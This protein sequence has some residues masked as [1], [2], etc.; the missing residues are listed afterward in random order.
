MIW[1][2]CVMYKFF[3][4]KIIFLPL[5]FAAH[6]EHIVWNGLLFTSRVLDFICE[7][8]F[9]FSVITQSRCF[10]FK[11]SGSN[12]IKQTKHDKKKQLYWIANSF[13]VP[14]MSSWK[15]PSNMSAHERAFLLINTSPPTLVAICRAAVKQG[16]YV[17]EIMFMPH[18]LRV[19]SIF[20]AHRSVWLWEMIDVLLWQWL[21]AE[22][23]ETLGPQWVS[24]LPK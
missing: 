23:G 17:S 8:S 2:K 4:H 24:S 22:P 6:K 16:W 5:I 20:N 11:S 18:I 3:L 21:E 13:L 14:L 7:R 9:K 12:I 15:F 19:I 1:H 10:I